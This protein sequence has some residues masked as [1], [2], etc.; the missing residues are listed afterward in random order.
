MMLHMIFPY[1]VIHHMISWFVKISTHCLTSACWSYKKIL[2]L[3]IFL[4]PTSWILSVEQV[5]IRRLHLCTFRLIVS[6]K[7]EHW[8]IRILFAIFFV[9]LL[10]RVVFCWTNISV[11]FV[12]QNVFMCNDNSKSQLLC[13]FSMAGKD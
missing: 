6:Y 7:W 9:T 10:G 5:T 2:A 1:H 12:S 8:F 11:K 3:V 13:L 4:V